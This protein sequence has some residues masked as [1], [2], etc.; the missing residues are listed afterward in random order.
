MAVSGGAPGALSLSASGSVPR[1]RRWVRYPT[2]GFL[3]VPNP[4]WRASGG[5]VSV[6]VHVKKLPPPEPPGGHHGG[7]NPNNMT[8]WQ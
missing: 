8:T 1:V 7:I 4:Y 2:G 6:T 3:F 5:S